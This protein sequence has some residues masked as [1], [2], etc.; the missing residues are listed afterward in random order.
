MAVPKFSYRW[1][2]EVFNPIDHHFVC[3]I[4]FKTKGA[5]YKK[6]F[7]YDWRFWTLAEV[8]ELLREAGFA[9]IEVHVDDFDDDGESNGI[10]RRRERFD[11]EGVWVAY[12]VGLT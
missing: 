7:S 10:F 12:I 4:D 6:A 9:G 1:H 11:N 5:T 8:G 3:H 2:Q